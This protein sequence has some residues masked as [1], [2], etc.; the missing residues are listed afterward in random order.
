MTEII[1]DD[2]GIL[3]DADTPQ[4]YKQLLEYHNRQLARPLI[5]VTIARETPFFD[6][7]TAMLLSL[8]DETGSVRMAC[9]RMQTSYSHGWNTIR[10]LENQ[11]QKS[12][13]SRNQGGSGGGSS[14]LTEDGKE[15]LRRF[16]QYEAWIREQALEQFPLFFD[17]GFWE[18]E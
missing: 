3:H 11:M 2:E 13:V 15:L 16:M 12:I 9:E 6:S 7:E 17:T 1:V 14:S 18:G 8:I 4:D 10:N 5:S